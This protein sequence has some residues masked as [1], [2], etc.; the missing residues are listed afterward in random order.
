M[1]Q[2]GQEGGGGFA[3]APLQADAGPKTDPKQ[4]K[5]DLPKCSAHLASTFLAVWGL[6]LGALEPFW[7]CF[8]NFPGG[9]REH[10]CSTFNSLADP[11]VLEGLWIT[12][13]ARGPGGWPGA[14]QFCD[15][16]AI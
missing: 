8:Q 16:Q 5:K 11:A 15:P 1:D 13:P 7:S 2:S 14:H 10:F 4:L 9:A 6:F 3:A 12:R